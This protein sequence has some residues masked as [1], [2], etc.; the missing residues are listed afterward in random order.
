MK[1]GDQQT[2]YHEDTKRTKAHEEILYKDA[3]WPSC[4]FGLREKAFIKDVS[5]LRLLVCSAFHPGEILV[6]IRILHACDEH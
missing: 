6:K 4:F 1:P 3:S 2:T 5:T